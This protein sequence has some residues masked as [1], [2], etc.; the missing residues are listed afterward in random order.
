MNR[1]M[2]EDLPGAITMEIMKR[3]M[4]KDL[5]LKGV[6]ADIE[7]GHMGKAAEESEYSKVFSEL[8]SWEGLIL[9]GERLLVPPNL[10]A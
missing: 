7:R 9:K 3:E 5:L 2:E 4:E 10:R 8:T 1:V 6:K